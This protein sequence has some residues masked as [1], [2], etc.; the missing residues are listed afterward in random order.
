MIQNRPASSVR[1]SGPSKLDKR[2]ACGRRTSR[3]NKRL[4]GACGAHEWA[5]ACKPPLTTCSSSPEY[6][7]STRR[8]VVPWT[9][10]GPARSKRLATRPVWCCRR[11]RHLRLLAGF[12]CSP[13]ARLPICCLLCGHALAGCSHDSSKPAASERAGRASG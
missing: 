8:R 6:R 13:A 9:V 3:A 4:R 1:A 5:E 11:H 10:Q 2:L 7:P 12:A